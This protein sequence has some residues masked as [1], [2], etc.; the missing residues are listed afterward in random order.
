MGSRR[1]SRDS[2]K[3]SSTGQKCRRYGG[4]RSKVGKD[5]Q[6]YKDFAK[7]SAE[8]IVK[9]SDYIV[10]KMDA[11]DIKSVGKKAAE[12]VG[13]AAEYMYENPVET[14]KMFTPIGDIEDG[15]DPN[16][17]LSERFTSMGTALLDAATTLMSGGATKGAKVAA[18]IVQTKKVDAVKDAKKA[19]ELSSGLDTADD[20]KKF[21]K[22][23]QGPVV[24]STKGAPDVQKSSETI[25]DR[26]I[27]SKENIEQRKAAWKEHQVESEKLVQ[28]V[29]E[30]L[31]AEIRKPSGHK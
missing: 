26:P 19:A 15:L 30:P 28:R 18:K 13:N 8:D 10:N 12:V 5:P 16:K 29:G 24:H 2:K 6:F 4:R 23:E 25:E 1:T 31:T 14:M 20:L 17:S 21:G 3:T 11:D 9:G 22:V 7:G 27:P